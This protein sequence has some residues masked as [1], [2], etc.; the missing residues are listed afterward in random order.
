LVIN[1]DLTECPICSCGFV[2]ETCGFWECLFSWAGT[3][4][5]NG[6]PKRIKNTPWQK[7]NEKFT[8]FDEKENGTA[9]WLTLKIMTKFDDEGK[10]KCGI[11]L[12]QTDSFCKSLECNHRYHTECLD[13]LTLKLK[14]RCVL[15]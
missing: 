15:C 10:G 12:K 9:Q 8:Y 4:I 11:C 13:A 3:N 6:C 5:V 7:I 2:T 1:S 14:T